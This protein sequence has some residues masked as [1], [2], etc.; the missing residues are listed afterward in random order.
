MTMT[1]LRQSKTTGERFL[2][3]TD[4]LGV[5]V[6][7]PIGP[8]EIAKLDK[9]YLNDVDFDGEYVDEDAINGLAIIS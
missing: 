7:G 4:D 8:D 2:V 9:S 3:R 6:S 1:T 5:F